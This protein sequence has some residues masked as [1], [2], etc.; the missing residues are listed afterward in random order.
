LTAS[1]KVGLAFSYQITPSNN[2]I[3]FNAT[4]LPAGLSINKTT[5]IISGTPRRG[6]SK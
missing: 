5:G 6:P 1:G 2:P 4:D 3:S